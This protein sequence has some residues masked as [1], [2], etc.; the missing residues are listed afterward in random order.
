M[1]RYRAPKPPSSK[2]I[3]QEGFNS[4]RHELDTLWRVTRPKVIQLVSEAA[5]QGDR[6]EN[7][8]YIYGKKQ[9][10]QIDSRVHFLRKRLDKITVV[11]SIP[12]NQ[13]KVYFSAWVKLVNNSGNIHCYRIVGPDEFNVEKSTISLDSPLSQQLIGK[14]LGDHIQVELPYKTE[15]YIIL[16][17]NYTCNP[18]NEKKE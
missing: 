11:D 1:G 4:L 2:Y 7:A 10:R 16:E 3:T 17:I 18:C 6:S 12:E 8:D 13:D 15:Q 9:L 5:A 14:S